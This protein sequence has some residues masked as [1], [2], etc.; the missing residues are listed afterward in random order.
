M[1][2]QLATQELKNTGIYTLLV[3]TK[4][5]KKTVPGPYFLS[6]DKHQNGR[7]L[8]CNSV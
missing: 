2:F 7:L 5:Q 8:R 6:S 3:H 4:I 1:L